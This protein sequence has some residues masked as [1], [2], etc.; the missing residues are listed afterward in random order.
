MQPKCEVVFERLY[1]PDMEID[2]QGGGSRVGVESVGEGAGD[3]GMAS[4][5]FKP[6]E[7]DAYPDL[8]VHTIA[9]DGI[10]IVVNHSVPVDDLSVDQVRAIFAGEITNWQEVGGHDAPIIVV[11]R[12]EG[13]G[14]RGAFEEIVMGETPITD[15]AIIRPCSGW[16]NPVVT[17]DDSIGFLSFGYLDD[18]VKPLSI[19]GVAPTVGNVRNG[20]YPI[21]RPLNLLTSGEPGEAVK[22]WLEF[23]LSEEGQAIVTEEGYIPMR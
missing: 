7:S 17:Y 23:A 8:Q 13:S 16:C 1:Y 4:R 6:S 21:I 19:D 9:R 3:V 20:T 11:S 12:E 5:D 14:T 22:A 15:T 18:S 10:A 2:V